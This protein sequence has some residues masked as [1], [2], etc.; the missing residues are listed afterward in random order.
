MRRAE[1]VPPGDSAALA[2]AI[3]RL[4]ED[5]G[6]AAALGARA[7]QRVCAEFGIDRMLVRLQAFYAHALAGGRQ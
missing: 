6:L 1:I 7:R 4:V 5:P 3:I 2:K